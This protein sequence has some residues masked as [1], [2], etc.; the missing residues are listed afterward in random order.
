M[1]E[2]V[3]EVAEVADRAASPAK[4]PFLVGWAALWS[5]IALNVSQVF[6]LDGSDGLREPALLPLAAGGFLVE[7]WLF[8]RA[9]RCLSPVV[10]T[11]AYG[12]TPAVVTILSVA[13]FGE[14][15]TLPKVA[16]VG[17]VTAGIVLL[18][19]AAQHEEEDRR[20]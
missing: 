3:A 4:P 9:V 15:L 11:A 20:I 13:A 1:R 8:G 14:A 18:A 5:A 19:T 12:A 17:V 6:L 2:L 10:A 16:G 7:L